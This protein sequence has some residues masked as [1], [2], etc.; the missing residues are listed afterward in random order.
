MRLRVF[1]PAV[2]REVEHGRRGIATAEG[3]VVAHVDPHAARAGLKT[4][5]L[6]QH[7]HGGVIAMEPSRRHDVSLDQP[8]QRLQDPRAGAH[9]VGQRR[10][11][12]QHAFPGV[13]LGLPVQRDVLAVFLEQ[14]HGEQARPGP[15]TRD[16]VE[17]C[18]RLSDALAGAAGEALA[19]GLD[20]GPLARHH[21]QRFGDVLAHL[22][23]AR[24]AAARAG[25][26]ARHHDAHTRQVGRE[27]LARRLPPVRRGR[28]S[29]LGGGLLSREGVRGSRGFELLELQL[30]LVEEALGPFGALAVEGSGE[31]GNLKPQVRD[32]RRVARQLRLHGGSLGLGAIGCGL[33]LIGSGFGGRQ[34]CAQRVDVDLFGLGPLRHEQIRS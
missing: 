21:L 34:G 23:Q 33:G 5:A 28:H 10:Q 4:D 16:G 29:G 13:A 9:L 24:A 31:L 17:G 20:H 15:A 19:H 11:A 22:R 12:E 8:E 7:R 18:R 27:G 14:H 1:A 32:Q 25:A 2:G 3:P 6:S 26:G 30:V